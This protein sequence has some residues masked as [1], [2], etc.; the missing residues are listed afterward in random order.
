MK[1]DY[2]SHS[3]NVQ[4][5]NDWY[6]H[7]RLCR[8]LVLPREQQCCVGGGGKGETVVGDLGR[9]KAVSEP[10]RSSQPLVIKG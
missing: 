4:E 9:W 6:L 2:V 5:E 8:M 3:V 1:E 7:T 10:H